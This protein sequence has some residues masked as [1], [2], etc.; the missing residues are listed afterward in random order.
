LRR[1]QAYSA[2]GVAAADRALTVADQ[3]EEQD[4]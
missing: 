4:P 1:G 2:P 3:E